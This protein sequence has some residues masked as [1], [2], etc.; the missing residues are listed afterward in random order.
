MARRVP[1]VEPSLA[2]TISISIR[3]RDPPRH[4]LEHL[5]D[6]LLFVVDGNDDG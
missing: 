1:S 3:R 4:A 6:R 2:I 5:V